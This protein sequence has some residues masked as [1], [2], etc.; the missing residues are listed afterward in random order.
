MGRRTQP[1]RPIVFL[2]GAVLCASALG[3]ATASAGTGTAPIITA[4]VSPASPDGANGWY[5]GNVMVDPFGINLQG[6]TELSRSADC[7]ATADVTTDTANA[8]L[9]CMVDSTGGSNSL[10]VPIKRDATDPTLAPEITPATLVLGGPGDAIPG[11]ADATSGVDTKGCDPVDTSTVGAH[12]LQC[13]ATDFA[14]NQATQMV[15]YTVEP[16]GAASAVTPT[17]GDGQAA[18]VFAQFA[19]ALAVTVTDA[20]GNPVPGETVTFHAPFSGPSADLS[21]PFE[22]TNANGVASI[23]AFAN[24][25]AGSYSV[26]GKVVAVGTARFDLRNAPAP[27]FSD[28]FAK[29]L[30]KWK[31]TGDVSIA[32]GAG[33]PAPSASLRASDGKTFATH[34]FGDTYATACASAWVRLNSLGGQAVALL[35]FRGTGDSGISR[36]SVESD[37]ELFVR[38]DRKGGVKL[39]GE[40]LPLGGW[41]EIE[42]CTEVGPKGS[43]SL[44]L[45][46]SKIVGWQQGLGDRRIAAIHLIEND[47][48]T[49]SLNVDG[50]LVDRSPGTPV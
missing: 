25:K 2:A 13:Q 33:K 17:K 29:G 20:Q 5:V 28:G 1:P 48:K 39:S 23:R 38:N 3:P 8:D 31:R 9:T 15:N 30:R 7:D 49:F 16:H 50:V 11:A 10:T 27:Y 6:Q 36:V 18:Y 32:S 21:R 19:S 34:R 24:D 46:G 22:V 14:G 43:I 37:R 40:R 41:H 4:N 26:R 35:R 42:L 12:S 44:Y 45:D 47:V